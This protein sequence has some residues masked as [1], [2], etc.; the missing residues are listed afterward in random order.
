[1]SIKERHFSDS[2]IL[3]LCKLANR[4]KTREKLYKKKKTKIKG[5]E[6]QK[7]FPGEPI[8]KGELTKKVVQN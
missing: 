8:G 1:M 2:W 5:C 4:L 6:Q 3:L 7:G